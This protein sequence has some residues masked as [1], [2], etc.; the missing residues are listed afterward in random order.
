MRHSTRTP[1]RDPLHR[2]GKW[3][4][5]RARKPPGAH[6]CQQPGQTWRGHRPHRQGPEPAPN[7][8]LCSLGSEP[9]P[10]SASWGTR[11]K[12]EHAG[13]KDSAS[14]LL[15]MP[16][17]VERQSGDP[18]QAPP[19]PQ[20]PARQRADKRGGTSTPQLHQLQS[21]SSGVSVGQPLFY[22]WLSFLWGHA[23]GA[24]GPG[25]PH[26]RVPDREYTLSEPTRNCGCRA[27]PGNARREDLPFHNH[28]GQRP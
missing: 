13:R 21:A 1:S 11:Q 19:E 4:P 7:S 9:G 8:N 5:T 23:T 12:P 14:C 18:G 27:G 24:S 17:K 10:S 26:V 20:T 15:G 16:N 3:G 6:Q 2:T 25:L 28:T 22:G